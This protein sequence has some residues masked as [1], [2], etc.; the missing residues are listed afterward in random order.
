M[1][2]P[3]RCYKGYGRYN[4]EENR[5]KEKENRKGLKPHPNIT[6]SYN[7]KKETVSSITVSFL[8]PKHTVITVKNEAGVSG[9]GHPAE[10]TSARIITV[11]TTQISE[12]RE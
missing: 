3:Y 12:K 5:C 8:F 1:L 11:N 4:R 10:K 6:T 9:R 7:V 2:I